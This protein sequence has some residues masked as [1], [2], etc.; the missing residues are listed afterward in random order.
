MK[1]NSKQ[2]TTTTTDLDM[3]KYFTAYIVREANSGKFL[4]RRAYSGRLRGIW[5]NKAESHIF[6]SRAKA[7]SCASNINHRR[8]DGLS[9]YYAQVMPVLFEREQKKTTTTNTKS[10]KTKTTPNKK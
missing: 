3:S 4:N 5:S 7:A 8:P 6:Y 9:S 1:S 2:Q 10:P